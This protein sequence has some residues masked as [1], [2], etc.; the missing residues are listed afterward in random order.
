MNKLFLLLA[1][2]LVAGAGCGTST[3]ATAGTGGAGGIGGA[4]GSAGGDG[5][6]PRVK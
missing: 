6:K 5:A 3:G 1:G 2:M 4:G